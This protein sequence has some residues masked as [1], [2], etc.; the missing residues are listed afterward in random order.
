MKNIALIILLSLFFGVCNS[1]ISPADSKYL[2]K[3]KK[4]AKTMG[5][6]F[7]KKDFRAF[8]KFTHPKVVEMMGG[9]KQMID[10][11]EKGLKQMESQEI[12]FIN[13]TFGE[14][15]K[16]F[17]AGNDFNVQFHRY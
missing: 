3:I 6:L 9:K 7:I 16:I 10:F 4:Q 1:Q 8:V 11:M 13:I 2:K 14:P 17:T 15:T 12:S 5:Q